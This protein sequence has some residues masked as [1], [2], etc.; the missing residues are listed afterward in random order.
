[1]YKLLRQW[2]RSEIFD[3][4]HPFLEMDVHI[5]SHGRPNHVTK[6]EFLHT[7]PYQRYIEGVDSGQNRLTP[8]RIT[9]FDTHRL[10]HGSQESQESPLSMT[11]GGQEKKRL[12]LVNTEVP[13]SAS[14]R[15]TPPSKLQTPSPYGWLRRHRQRRRTYEHSPTPDPRLR[16]HTH[17]VGI[18][19]SGPYVHQRPS[20]FLPLS[21]SSSSGHHRG[22][23]PSV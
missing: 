11:P 5:H 12:L 16:V 18:E 14:T 9:G 22:R 13:G 8:P 23:H 17:L 20:S 3:Q 21:R 4:N 2:R 10:F 1:M 19:T 7:L 6:V 15:T